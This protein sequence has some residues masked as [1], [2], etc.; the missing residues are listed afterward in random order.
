MTNEEILEKQVE[1]LE[2]LLQLRAAIIEDLEQKV[3]DLQN[4]AAKQNFPGIGYPGVINTPWISPPITQ[5]WLPG[6]SGTTVIISNTCPDGTPHQYPSMWGGIGSPT[7]T[8][9]GGMASL[10]AAS[11]TVTSGYCAP[12]HTT[13]LVQA[14]DPSDSGSNVFT[15]QN[16]AK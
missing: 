3:A 6:Q 13:G 1:A 12:V 2:K 8:K 5:P 16:A 15:L 11:G 7:C 9:C 10:G 14:L 4:Q